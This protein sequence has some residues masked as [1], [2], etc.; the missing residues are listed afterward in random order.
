M[1]SVNSLEELISRFRDIFSNF[2]FEEE[3]EHL[4]LNRRDSEQKRQALTELRALYISLWKVSLDKSFPDTSESIFDSF[5]NRLQTI[6]NLDSKTAISITRRVNIYNGFL[7]QNK[8][9]NYLPVGDHLLRTVGK[10]ETDKRATL[11]TALRIRE[12]DSY[13]FHALI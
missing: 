8:A 1:G 9:Q 13:I 12:V 4:P 6:F 2:D 7:K 10:P 3:L 11:K 5:L